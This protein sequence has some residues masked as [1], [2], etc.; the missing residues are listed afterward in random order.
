MGPVPYRLGK[1]A[2]VL[3]NLG[4]SVTA[5][6]FLTL[7]LFNFD[8]VRYHAWHS[9]KISFNNL[10]LRCLSKGVLALSAKHCYWVNIGSGK[11]VIWPVVIHLQWFI[12]A[13]PFFT[14][15]SVFNMQKIHLQLMLK[16][17]I[18][19]CVIS[20][21]LYFN[22]AA[23]CLQPE[24]PLLTIPIMYTKHSKSIG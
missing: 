14:V 12:N 10:R 8:C 9:K 24:L 4:I 18:S 13:L 21:N 22:L 3:A 19:D 11:S 7:L 5:T 16:Q 6:T 2:V 15:C 17:S 23:L 20:T 1:F